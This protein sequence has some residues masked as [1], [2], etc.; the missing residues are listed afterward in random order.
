MTRRFTLS[1]LYA[2]KMHAL[3]FRNWRTH[4]LP[5]IQNPKEL[6]RSNDY[7]HHL[8]DRINYLPE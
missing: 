8:A 4:V 3:L 1:D 2:E 7:F 6:D 5:F